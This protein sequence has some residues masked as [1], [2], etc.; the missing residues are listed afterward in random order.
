MTRFETEILNRRENREV[1][2]CLSGEWI[3]RV[4]RRKRTREIILDMDSSVSE[5]YGTQ[6]GSAYN[7]HFGC[8]CYHPLFCFNQ[9]GDLERVALRPGNG[10]SADDWRSVLGPVVSRYRPGKLM[11]FFR[12]DAA[13]ACP[14]V[15]SFLEEES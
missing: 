13:F 8:T 15:Y 14:E 6:Q 5:T 9:L 2:A 10:H 1:L 4:M 3:D 12:R 7:G 11:R